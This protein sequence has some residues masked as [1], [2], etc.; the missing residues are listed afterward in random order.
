SRLEVGRQLLAALERRGEGSQVLVPPGAPAIE[1]GGNPE[2][3]GEGGRGEQGPAKVHSRSPSSTRPGKGKK[4]PLGGPPSG[5]LNGP[6]PLIHPFLSPTSSDGPK[7]LT[8]KGLLISLACS[9]YSADNPD[10]FLPPPSQL[11]QHGR[12]P[13]QRPGERGPPGRAGG[14]PR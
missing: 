8:S 10:G 4:R 14:G 5:N 3:G 2:G 7:T 11:S 9:I 6:N 1:G 13:G 12:P